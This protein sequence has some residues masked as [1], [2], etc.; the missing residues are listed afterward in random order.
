MPRPPPRPSLRVGL[1][2]VAWA[3][4]VAGS[5]LLLMQAEAR[6][7]EDAEAQFALRASIASRFV[8]TYV[9]EL[10]DRQAEQGARRLASAEVSERRFAR[11]AAD[12]GFEA[13]VLL[14]RGGR[15]LRVSPPSP[16]LLGT[17]V[18]G[19]YEHLA[20]AVAGKVAVSKVVPS[21]ARG[22]PV[23]A[24]AVPFS[25]R[26]GRRVYSGAYDIATTPAGAYLR[27]AIP[28]AGSRLYLIDAGGSVIA[29]N[30]PPLRGVRT[31]AELEPDLVRSM[32]RHGEEG[33]FDRGDDE[34]RYASAAIS[35]TP[36]RVVVV[37]P[38]RLL[39]SAS[40]GAARWLPWVAMAGFV[41]ASLLAVMLL[42]RLA[43][44]RGR[45]S[46]L[47]ARLEKV[48]R[49]DPLTDMYNRRGLDELLERAVSSAIRHGQTLSLLM[50]DV[51]HFKHVN[52]SYGHPAGDAVLARIAGELDQ[53]LRTEDVIGRWGGEEFLALLPDTGPRAAS[54]LAER[55]R[56]TIAALDVPIPDGSTIAATISIGITSDVHGTAEERISAADRALY[57]AKANG[58]DRV[59]TAVAQTVAL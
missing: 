36:W 31:L 48:I 39:Y 16:S 24:F 54:A 14:D 15:L 42:L 18:T 44:S 57:S 50:I 56:A 23:V 22:V 21:L 4:V 59:E 11:V 1:S 6:T 55:L 5:I 47:N 34:Q 52:D 8:T 17:D 37:A 28:I 33:S 27:N 51:D 41:L 46:A 30:G 45:L 35:G 7:R 3:V 9:G 38:S 40:T 13:A 19:K 29:Q 25:T 10:T 20:T 43:D 26:A 58:R 2:L 12:A 53:A 32:T 49:V